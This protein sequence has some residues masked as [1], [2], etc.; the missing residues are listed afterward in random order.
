MSKF[1]GQITHAWKRLG[2]PLERKDDW[3]IEIF[4]EMGGNAIKKEVMEEGE[5]EHRKW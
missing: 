4:D 1:I 2:M 5:N 3:G